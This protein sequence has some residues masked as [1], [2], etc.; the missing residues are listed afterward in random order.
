MRQVKPQSCSATMLQVLVDSAVHLTKHMT[1]GLHSP[2]PLLVVSGHHNK[3]VKYTTHMAPF[4]WDFFC[5]SHKQ[6]CVV[7]SEATFLGGHSGHYYFK[8]QY[9]AYSYLW[10]PASQLASQP[11]SR[12]LHT[13][14]HNVKHSFPS[15]V[16]IP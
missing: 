9:T 16:G 13:V 3:M 5:G 1:F 11:T 2:E 10:P 15:V 12:Y 14:C 8:W 4:T 6:W 7:A